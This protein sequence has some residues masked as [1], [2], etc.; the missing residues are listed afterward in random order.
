MKILHSAAS[1]LFAS[2]AFGQWSTATLSQPRAQLGAASVGTKALF[3]GGLSNGAVSAVVDIYDANTRTWSTASLS[4]A[5]TRVAG[6]SAAG[7][8]VFAGGRS[9]AGSLVSRV[10]IYDAASSTWSTSEMPIPRQVLATSSG[11]RIFFAGGSRVDIFDPATGA[12]TLEMMPTTYASTVV[13]AGSLVLFSSGNEVDLFDVTTDTWS[14]DALSSARTFPA[15]TA[16]LGRAFF[17]GGEDPQTWMTV[18]TVDIYDVATGTWTIASLSM[19]R[20]RIV[21]TSVGSL[22]I[23]AGGLDSF[24]GPPV[25]VV[26]IYDVATDTWTVATLTLGRRGMAATTVA[27]QVLF[28]GGGAGGVSSDVVDIFTPELGVRYCTPA[29]DNSSGAP[30]RIAADGSLFVADQDLTLIAEDLPAGEFGYFLVGANQGQFQPP[31]SQGVLCLACGFQGCSGIGRFSQAGFII[32]GPTGSIDVDLTGL[33]TS[34]PVAVQA[35]ETWNFQCWYRDQGSSNFTDA[36]S[37]T[38]L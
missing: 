4:L 15:G 31:G 37:V 2:T 30:A 6:A 17:G 18:D 11:G 34:P 14:S 5:R 10:D 21:A 22:A 12:W 16:V 7:K 20:L 36:V 25:D 8:A 32:Q 26:D 19:P 3:A 38:F 24:S 27:G 28:A 23:F 29:N 13:A 9:A 1:I 33:P 35:G